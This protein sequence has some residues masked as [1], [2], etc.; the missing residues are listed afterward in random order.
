MK[1][2]D[3]I[4]N[5][6]REKENLEEL[7]KSHVE[8]IRVMKRDIANLNNDLLRKKKKIHNLE[9]EIKSPNENTQKELE[10]V[11]SELRI[12]KEEYDTLQQKY[13]NIKPQK[14]SNK[15]KS[16][17]SDLK[18][19]YEDLKKMY[20]AVVCE[21]EEYKRIFDEIEKLCDS[22]EQ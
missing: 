14:A 6:I 17:L 15:A 1:T 21:N 8:T 9:S 10:A 3:Y 4:K 7:C 11:K 22:E 2:I 12:L 13:D 16:E 20:D 5:L 19:K 18:A